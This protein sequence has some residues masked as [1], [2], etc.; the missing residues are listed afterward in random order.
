MECLE[1]QVLFQPVAGELRLDCRLG[2][3]FSFQRLANA[4]LHSKTHI[5]FIYIRGPFLIDR[6]RPRARQLECYAA[7]MSRRS[8]R[9]PPVTPTV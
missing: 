6:A 2:L 5:D 8:P 4:A 1:P 9:D 3:T 7:K